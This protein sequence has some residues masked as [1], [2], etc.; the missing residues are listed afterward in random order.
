MNG[1][2]GCS[3]PCRWQYSGFT[4]TSS[5]AFCTW[6]AL[7]RQLW[8]ETSKLYSYPAQPINPK[9]TCTGCGVG[10]HSSQHTV[11][12]RHYSRQE[13]CM[14]VTPST[15][16]S[17]GVLQLLKLSK[18]KLPQGAARF[19]ELGYMIYHFHKD[20]STRSDDLPPSQLKKLLCKSV[21]ACRTFLLLFL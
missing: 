16:P 12:V 9:A 8:E 13:S 21:H 19:N 18:T 11:H 5:N 20:S 2:L 10:L 6:L 4:L 17:R 3:W 14:L 15:C 7:F 1:V